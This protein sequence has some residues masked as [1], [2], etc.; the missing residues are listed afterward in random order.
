MA[1]VVQQLLEGMQLQYPACNQV[2]HLGK[3]KQHQRSGC[4]THIR[5]HEPTAHKIIHQ[6]ATTPPTELE[7]HAAAGVLRRMLTQEGE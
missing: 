3:L 6:A 1:P 2:T 4:K 5:V 7:Q